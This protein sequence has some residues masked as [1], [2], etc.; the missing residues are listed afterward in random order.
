MVTGILANGAVCTSAT[1]CITAS[2]CCTG[3]SLTKAGTAV[4]TTL[5]CWEPGTDKNG[6]FTPPVGTAIAGW[7]S[8]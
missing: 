3:V 8:G 7:T 2:A 5:L 4:V 1:A 6:A